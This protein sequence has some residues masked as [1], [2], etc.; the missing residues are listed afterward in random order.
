M[1]SMKFKYT[2]LPAMPSMAFPGRKSVTIP[3]IDV[4]IFNAS[5]PKKFVYIKALV[6]SGAGVSIFP[7]AIGNHIGI[8]VKNDKIQP[9]QGIN[10]GMIEVYRHDIV[11][12]VGGW[13]FKTLAFFT[14][15]DTAMPVLGQI[16]FFDLFKVTF[17]YSKEEIELK[18][19]AKSIKIDSH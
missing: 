15:A 1:I 2:R 13:K 5:D 3:Y 12:E 10:M 9:I 14:Y 17:N 7:A 11:L 4:G 6:D 19:I 18:N 16:G 8:K